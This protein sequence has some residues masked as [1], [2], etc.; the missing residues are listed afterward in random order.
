[1]AFTIQEIVDRASQFF[2]GQPT[3]VPTERYEDGSYFLSL[4]EGLKRVSKL[5]ALPAAHAAIALLATQ[6]TQLP[7][8]VGRLL[9]AGQDY[10]REIED[11][12]IALLLRDPCTFLD[13]W[14]F[15][16]WIY[17][18]L[19]SSGNAYAYIRRVRGLPVELI[20][21][22]LA[23][24]PE[25]VGAGFRRYEIN[26]MQDY[27]RASGASPMV[28]SDLDI[29]SLHGPDFD[30][31]V[32]PSPVQRYASTTLKTIAAAMGHQQR[33]F[34][35]QDI[36]NAVTV[37]A[38]LRDRTPQQ[39]R[40]L[41]KLLR[42]TIEEARKSG[43][44]PVFPP[45]FNLASNTGMSPADLQLVDLLKWTIE[46][47]C[48]CWGVPPRML[49]HYHEGFRQSKFE[50]QQADFERL[51]LRGHS[52]RTRSQATRSLIPA[53]ERSEGVG[54]LLPTDR[55]R[56]GS[57]SEEVAA[58]KMAVSD[59]GFVTIN[60]GRRRLGYPDHEDGDRL[61]SP[62]GAPAQGGGTGGQEPPDPEDMDPDD[63]DEG[64]QED[65]NTP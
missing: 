28:V 1:M 64:A 9:D 41:S 16:E 10:W 31:L 23:A 44:F 7:F 26:L 24:A 18:C 42:E 34:D 52:L 3:P 35:G 50:Y 33:A 29:F 55:A 45:G 62:K 59:G 6:M 40:D 27:R 11:H 54:V 51:S 21:A 49:G 22:T 2:K 19:F 60:E 25:W 37:D 14:Q 39:L 36:R 58:V 13:P 8:S 46:D 32:S 61:L 5:D 63:E 20:P 17:T 15:W 47:V 43:K 4:T 38:A 53:V 12:P 65:E 56:M 57:F 48:R 30:G